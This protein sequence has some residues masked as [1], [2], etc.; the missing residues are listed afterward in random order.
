VID[1]PKNDLWVERYRPKKIE[2]LVLDDNTRAELNKFIKNKSI[3]HLLL[4][5]GAGVGKTTIAKILLRELDCDKLELNASSERGIDIIRNKV[6][7]FAMMHTMRQWKIVFMDEMDMLTFDAQT[8]LRNVF[9]TY[10]DYVRF[11]CTGNFGNKIIPAIKS[12]CQCL[13]FEHMDKKSVVKLL[14]GIL[15]KEDVKYD[16]DDFLTLVDDH[17]PDIRAM[18]NKLQLDTMDGKFHYTRYLNLQDMIVLID[19][20]KQGDLTNIRKMNLDYAEAYKSMFDRID[21][22]TSDYNTKIKMSLAVADHFRDEAFCAD[23]EINFAACCMRLMEALG[24]TVK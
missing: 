24:A 4:L 21:D 14:K 11:I 8:A 6:T 16:A 5:G 17:Y 12:R 18:I 13:E 3:P 22:L 20:I 23:R 10:S 1:N 2:D 9:E 7:S 15:D 19:R